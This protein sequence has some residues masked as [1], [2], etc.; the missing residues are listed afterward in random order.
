MASLKFR[1][2]ATESALKGNGT[3]QNALNAFD[4][5]TI[6]FIDDTQKQYII[7]SKSNNVVTYKIYYGKAAVVGVSG[8]DAARILTFSDGSEIKVT[9]NNVEH[10]TSSDTANTAKSVAWNNV[11]GKPTNFVTTDG[12]QTI[13]GAKTFTNNVSLQGSTNADSITTEDLIVNGA[14]RFVSGLTGDLKGNVVGNV[15]GNVTGNV[16][17]SSG[18]CTGNALTA[19]TLQTARSINGTSFNGSQAITTAKWGTARN[20]T[21]ADNTNEHTQVNNS[22]DGSTNF[23]LKLPATI[24]ANII[25]N[26]STADSAKAVAWANVTNKPNLVTTDTEQT[27]TGA[28]IFNNNTTF[29]NETDVESL[30]AD[31][32]LVTGS[33]RFTNTINGNLKGNVEGNLTG[34]ASTATTAAICTG[35]SA[36]AT[37]LTTNAGSTNIP[38]YFTG[39]KPSAISITAGTADTEQPLVVVTNNNELYKTSGITANYSKNS[40]TATTFKGNLEG[41]ALTATTALSCSGNS[42][43]ATLANEAKN[44]QNTTPE[45]KDESFFSKVV[46]EDADMVSFQTLKGNSV[47]WNQLVQKVTQY[48]TTFNG[49]TFYPQENGEVLITGVATADS[50]ASTAH[51]LGYS[52]KSVANHK[53]FVQIFGDETRTMKLYVTD[54]RQIMTDLGIVQ[55]GTVAA[56]SVLFIPKGYDCGQGVRLRFIVNDL[57]QMFGA[58]N[59]PSTYEEFLSRKPKVA[60]EYAYNEGTIVNNKVEKVVTTGRNIWDEEWEVGRINSSDGTNISGTDSIRSKNYIPV[61]S[62]YTYYVFCKAMADV[63]Q[64]LRVRFYDANKNYVG[65]ANQQTSNGQMTFAAEVKYIRFFTYEGQYGSTYNHDIC[66]NISD[67][68]INGKY[69]P[70]EEHTFDLS[71][72]KDIK[73]AEGVKL[74]EDGMRSAGTAFDEAA[75]GRAIKRIGVYTFNGTEDWRINTYAQNKG[76]MAYQCYSKLKPINDNIRCD[77][78]VTHSWSSSPLAPMTIFAIPKNGIIIE[79][80]G[81]Q[82]LDD[83]KASLEAKPLDVYYELAE[84]IEVELPYGINHT[85]PVWKDGMMYAESSQSSTPI[86]CTNAYYTNIRESVKKFIGD[87]DSIYASTSGYN[88]HGTWNIDISGKASNAITAN[89][90]I[91]A[92]SATTATTCTGNAGTA[93]TLQNTR[94]INGTDFNGSA[95]ITT[96]KWGTAR[97]ITI[98]DGTNSGTATSVDGSGAITLNLPRTIKANLSGNASSATKATNDGNG[99]TITS[100]YATKTERAN[101]DITAASLTASKLTLTRAAGNITANIPTWNQDTTG[102]AAKATA[103]AKGNN[104]VNTYATKAEVAALPKSMVIKGTLDATHALPT[105]GMTEG[106]TYIVGSSGTY[107]KI[108]CK[109]GD[110]FVRTSNSWLRI[111]AGDEWE[112]NENTIKGI[113]VNNAGHAD[114][115]DTAVSAGSATSDSNGNNIASTY[116]RIDKVYNDSGDYR[117]FLG[118]DGSSSAWVKTTSNGLLPHTSGNSSNGHSSLGTSSWYFS[119]AYIQNIYGY[120]NGNISGSSTSCSGNS[121]TATKLQTAR[122]IWGQNFDGTRSISGDINSTGNI[123]PSTAISYDLGSNALS[124]RYVYTTWVGAPSGNPLSFGAANSTHLTI[125][126]SGNVG[127]GTTSPTSKLH[128]AGT[129]YF[130]SDV[131]SASNIIAGGYIKGETVKISSGCTLEYSSTDKC[132]RFVFN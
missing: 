92:T 93:T 59:E 62:R 95:D 16:S 64:W 110:F 76:V 68:A 86:V 131:S 37:A 114:T 55:W 11:T 21:I 96:S 45:T 130:A 119:K 46:T 115:A 87:A 44:L 43:T 75:K 20:I 107:N 100:T 82:S 52:Y 73:D 56:G 22:I 126:T 10:A 29:K 102:T 121:A 7:T 23:T 41:N 48:E 50:Y 104:I 31:S 105:S 97:N 80:D 83:F 70:Y 32:L 71:W 17:G 15:T 125:D 132:V 77:R 49:L 72:I 5:G 9:I 106:D 60:D 13:T 47:V 58:G 67:P 89:S 40:I 108:A 69:F 12:T 1:H 109:V 88:A 103:D 112:Y 127:I 78:F 116:A 113:K 61:D 94:K 98:S 27:I 34:N 79:T 128:V 91:T 35:N 90:A 122:T 99:N 3:V 117:Q 25:G 18:S 28:K 36:T 120:L 101:N 54:D 111:P 2:Y 118:T 84:P 24:K 26:A 123:R 39:G 6:V 129:G 65:Y 124:Y 81:T 63:P 42:A 38:V 8:T 30:T 4:V 19:T 14:A 74:F 57:T 53:A 66:I 85:L 33:A 51:Y